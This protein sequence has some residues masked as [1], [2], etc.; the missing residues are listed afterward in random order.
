MRTH[1]CTLPMT[2][3]P[4]VLVKFLRDRPRLV[5]VTPYWPASPWFVELMSLTSQSPRNLN[6]CPGDLVQPPTGIQNLYTQFL[7]LTTCLFLRKAHGHEAC[8][9]RPLSWPLRSDVSLA[10]DCTVYA[11][12]CGLTT[13]RSTK[14]DRSIFEILSSLIFF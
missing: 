11:G 6:L 13:A 9:P 3:I 5:P 7:D 4:R 1:T 10:I 8:P 2:L 14:L 12:L